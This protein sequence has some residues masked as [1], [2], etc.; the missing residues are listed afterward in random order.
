[1]PAPIPTRM[2]YVN[3]QLDRPEGLQ[4]K[5][6]PNGESGR[7]IE[8]EHDRRG[9]KLQDLRAVPPSFV[10]QG[11]LFLE[12]P[13]LAVDARDA[14]VRDR[15]HTPAIEALLKQQ[16]GVSEVHVFDHTLR[17]FEGERVPAQHVHVDY[18]PSSGPQRVRDLLAPEQAEQWLSGHYGIVNVWQP[19]GHAVERDPLAFA[20]AETVQPGDWVNIDILYPDRCG[21]IQ[22]LVYNPDHRWYFASHMRPDEAIVFNAFDS[23][24]KPPVA[25]TAAELLDNS[26]DAPTR[27]S[28]ETRVLV[29]Y[30]D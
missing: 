17:G 9:V 28:L 23:A 27:T 4:I 19:M 22:G 30:P 2:A 21:Q 18:S 11:M 14:Q 24:G 6:D 3:Y 15:L 8:P 16:L 12:A 26:N 7:R 29:R 5:V 1:M 13:S 25:H 10:T 20:D